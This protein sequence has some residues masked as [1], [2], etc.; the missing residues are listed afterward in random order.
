MKH[1]LLIK[2][3]IV[4]DPLN[5]VMGEKKD[6]AIK[7]G[8]IVEEV[9]KDAKVIDASGKLVVPGGVDSHSHVAGSKVNVGRIMRP[10]DGRKMREPKT[11]ILRSQGGFS[12]P[13][14]IT[15]GYRYAKM[16]YTT[17]MEAAMPPLKA[18]HTQEEMRDTPIL[19][20]AAFTVMG[21]N[22]FIMEYLKEGDFDKCAAYAAWLLKATRGYA[23]KLVNPGGVEAWGFGKNVNALD[24]PVPNFEITPREIVEGL[25]KVNEILRLPHS[26][27]AH[28][29]RLGQPGCAT[30]TLETFKVPKDV[31]LNTVSDREHTFYVTHVQF[32]AFGGTGWKD[33]ESGVKELADYV[34][35][36]KYMVIDTGCVTYDNTTTMTGDGP[37]EFNVQRLSGYKWVNGDVE[38]ECGSGIVPFVFMPKNPVHSVQWAI[39]LE[40]ALLVNDPWRVL[41]TT[42]HP[43]GGPFIRYPRVYAWLMSNKYR[44]EWLKKSHPWAT[45]RSSLATIDRE[46]TLE[47]I[48]I[49]TRAATAKILGLNKIKGHIGVGADA[50]VTIYDVNPE[51]F[52][53]ANNPKEVENIFS[54]ALYTIKGGEIVVRDKEIVN[55]TQGRT[56]WVSPKVDKDLEEEVLKEIKEKFRAYYTINFNNYEVDLEYLKNP[57]EISIETGI[58]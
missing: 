29:N 28:C 46:Y 36:N 50:D 39:G 31:K 4:V 48:I 58:A 42:D 43:N 53:F 34:N 19:D 33:F 57:V 2:N 32:N 3:G 37:A 21:N 1:E 41:I 52:D 16:G 25:A 26:A 13:N 49:N 22:W 55:V 7:N 9:S 30:I 6:I 23:I 20:E 24:D 17:V 15:T 10:E 54:N 51:E 27:H 56:F 35:Q 11:D 12:V 47:E 5:N 45:E 38:A 18:R 44:D 40:L 8:K 14:T